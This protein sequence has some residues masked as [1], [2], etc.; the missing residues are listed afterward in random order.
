MKKILFVLC[1]VSLL[2]MGAAG[3]GCSKKVDEKMPVSFEK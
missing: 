1:L 2:I 3:T